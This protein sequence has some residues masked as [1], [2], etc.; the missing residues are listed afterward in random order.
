MRKNKIHTKDNAESSHNM[1]K[2]KILMTGI[3]LWTESVS[4]GMQI[5]AELV[6]L[7]G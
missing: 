2:I 4:P 7:P 3:G 5:Q 1:D 6:T